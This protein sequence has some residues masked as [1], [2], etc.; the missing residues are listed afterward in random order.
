MDY[1]G[2]DPQQVT[3]DGYLNLMPTWSPDRKSLIYTGYRDR[4]QQIMRRELATGREEVLVAPASLNITATFCSRR[5]INH[6]CR[7]PR[8]QFRHLSDRIGQ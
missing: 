1:D 6:L 3:A 7:S 5:K 8:R 4:K 2:Y